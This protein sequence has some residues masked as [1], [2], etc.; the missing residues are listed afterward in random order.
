[1]KATLK[2]CNNCFVFQK[3]IN[4]FILRKVNYFMFTADVQKINKEWNRQNVHM[5]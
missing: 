2:M 3:P 4:V 5:D 1:M